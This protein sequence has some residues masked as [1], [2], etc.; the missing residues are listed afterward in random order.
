MVEKNEQLPLID[1]IPKN[2]ELM[3]KKARRYYATVRK[4]LAI[5]EVEKTE[6]A[7][8]RDEVAKS[9][10]QPLENGD[11]VYNHEGVDILLKPPKE[12]VLTVVVD[13]GTDD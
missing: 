13:D 8:L 11:L 2:A 7:E 4:R 6:K 3:D 1:T 12:G 10:L 9:G 5:Q